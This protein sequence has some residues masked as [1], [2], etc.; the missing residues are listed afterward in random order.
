L[1]RGISVDGHIIF[2]KM[3]DDEITIVRV[4]NGKRD[5]KSLFSET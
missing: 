5:L 3:I 4:V 2:Y 1:L